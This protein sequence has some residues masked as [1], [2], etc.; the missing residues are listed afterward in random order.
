MEYY[1][2]TRGTNFVCVAAGLNQ[3]WWGQ[4]ASLLLNLCHAELYIISIINIKLCTSK[5]GGGAEL[6]SAGLLL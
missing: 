5:L 1:T 6:I 2:F 4:S 3:Q